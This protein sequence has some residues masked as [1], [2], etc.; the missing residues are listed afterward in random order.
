MAHDRF[1]DLREDAFAEREGLLL[2]HL[3][4][5][6]GVGQHHENLGPERQ[7][8]HPA[9][10]EEVRVEREE[11]GTADEVVHRTLA[12]G[13]AVLGL[14]VAVRLEDLGD[15][16]RDDVLDAELGR[17]EVVVDVL[18]GRRRLRHAHR[19]A[20]EGRASR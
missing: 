3:A 8:E 18:L 17:D 16:E 1:E 4:N 5:D 11:D 6:D 15:P 10:P 19:V 12:H 9:V 7:L 2:E 13:R 20:A 14:L